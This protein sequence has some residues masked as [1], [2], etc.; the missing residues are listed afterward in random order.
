MDQYIFHSDDV[1][2]QTVFDRMADGVPVTDAG[3]G[4]NLNVNV[5]PI[6]QSRFAR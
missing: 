6:L 4:V 1:S 2:G 3:L 5:H